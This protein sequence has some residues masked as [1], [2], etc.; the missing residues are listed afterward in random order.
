L[1][2]VAF[3]FFCPTYTYLHAVVV[4]D[5]CQDPYLRSI[6]LPCDEYTDMHRSLVCVCCTLVLFQYSTNTRR[7]IL[8]ACTRLVAISI[9]GRRF[10]PRIRLEEKRFEA[11]SA[12][13]MSIEK[14]SVH[15]PSSRD[16]GFVTSGAVLVTDGLLLIARSTG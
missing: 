5:D 11:S 9:I 6:H 1:L 13:A 16:A 3:E 14:L 15:V 12:T 4:M 2:H 8:A 7:D 10:P